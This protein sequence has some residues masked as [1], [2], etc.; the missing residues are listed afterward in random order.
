MFLDTQTTS[1]LLVGRNPQVGDKFSP[2]PQ[3]PYT[4]VY[5]GNGQNL[6]PADEGVHAQA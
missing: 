6:T 5:K 2:M 3:K 4:F 1:A